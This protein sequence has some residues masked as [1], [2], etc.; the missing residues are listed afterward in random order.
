MAIGFALLAPVLSTQLPTGAVVLVLFLSPPSSLDCG[1]TIFCEF[2]FCLLWRQ[3]E[4]DALQFHLLLVI[5]ALQI[6]E[7]Q[8]AL[9][10]SPPDFAE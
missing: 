10:R 4:Q 8:F 9:P 7:Q 2:F 5:R 3:I 6:A 1:V